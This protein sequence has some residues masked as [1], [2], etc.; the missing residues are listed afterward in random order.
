MIVGIEWVESKNWV[1]IIC[2]YRGRVLIVD[3]IS[4][5]FLLVLFIDVFG[6]WL[7]W[8]NFIWEYVFIL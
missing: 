1:L 4:I 3:V 5:N 2:W 7:G 8:G 6:V